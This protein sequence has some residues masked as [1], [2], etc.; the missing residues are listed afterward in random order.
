[1]LAGY[2]EDTDELVPEMNGTPSSG[3][4]NIDFFNVD[5]ADTYIAK[6]YGLQNELRV[7]LEGA[8]YSLT[9]YSDFRKGIV[10]IIIGQK[11][12]VQ[13]VLNSK[14]S[15][16]ALPTAGGKSLCYQLPAYVL[17]NANEFEHTMA[18]VVSPTIS[19][20]SDQLRCLPKYLKGAYLS[21]IGQTVLIISSRILQ[22]KMQLQIY[23]TRKWIYFSFP[24][25]E[26]VPHHFSHLR[27][28]KSFQKLVLSAS[29]KHIA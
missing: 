22:T 8:L 24:L 2:N 10:V 13:N 17:K 25:K 9:G 4:G 1:L 16:F 11:E 3:P 27:N 7:N 21:S 23:K 6:S 5:G 14:S 18:I 29:M 15:L 12:I 28:Q 19:L 20:I 26:F